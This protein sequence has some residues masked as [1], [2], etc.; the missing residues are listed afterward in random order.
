MVGQRWTN[1][2]TISTV[3]KRH[4]FKAASRLVQRRRRWANVERSLRE[5]LEPHPSNMRYCP[6]AGPES[7]TVG[8]HWTN[9]GTISRD[10]PQ[11][12]RDRY[13]PG[14]VRRSPSV[15]DNR[16]TFNQP[17]DN[18]SRLD[19]RSGIDF[20]RLIWFISISTNHEGRLYKVPPL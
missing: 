20:V 4:S 14:L 16:P 13:S 9:S 10:F 3:S 6:R 15:A 8:Q 11:P 19:P 1:P 5:S 7:Q 18:I 12:A 2:E 17:W